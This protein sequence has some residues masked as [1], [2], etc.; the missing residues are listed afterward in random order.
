[1]AVRRAGIVRTS[2]CRSAPAMAL[3]WLP[4]MMAMKAI[5]KRLPITVPPNWRNFL[6][7][8][9]SPDYKALSGEAAY[10]RLY[11][12]ATKLGRPVAQ[13]FHLLQHV[14]W[15][16]ATPEQHR[17]NLE[18]FVV[19]ADTMLADP[20][21]DVNRRNRARYYVA[22]ALRELGQFDAAKARLQAMHAEWELAVA[23]QIMDTP[24]DPNF[25]NVYLDEQRTDASNGNGYGFGFGANITQLL[26]AVEARDID[27]FP[28]SL[29]GDKWANAVCRDLDDSFPPA[30]ASTKANCAKR[31]AAKTDKYANLQKDHDASQALLANPAKLNPLCTATPEDKREPILSEACRLSEY[32]ANQKRMEAGSASL[33]K[34]PKALD[35]QCK[36]LKFTLNDQPKTALGMACQKRREVTNEA[37]A[38]SLA[39]KFRTQPAEYDRMCTMKYPESYSDDP[40]ESACAR[41]KVERDD[42]RDTEIE[43]R[44]SKMSEAEIWAECEKTNGGNDA[45]GYK[46]RFRCSD[47]SGAREEA[48]WQTLESDPTLLAEKCALPFEERE[49]W[50]QMRCHYR[51][52]SM[53]DDAAKVMAKDHTAL[54]TAC[55]ATPVQDRDAILTKVCRG[56]RK[57]LVVRFDELPF[58]AASN[59]DWTEARDH[60]ELST[61]CYA[62]VEKADAAYARYA[63]DPKSLRA[64]CV[65]ETEFAEAPQ[66]ADTCARYAMGVDVFA[67]WRAADAADDDDFEDACLKQ[68]QSKSKS[69]AA[70]G[71]AAA[72]CVAKAAAKIIA[73]APV[74][75]K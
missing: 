41:V 61:A 36:S 55:A 32:Y 62:T 28:V 43:A 31:M 44:L 22:N 39:A 35:L 3:P 53:E 15:V 6:R 25:E 38:T 12:L 60:S 72:G 54:V 48:Q 68:A 27:Y 8:I 16:G 58:S 71:A 7:L 17:A 14:S 56:Y 26:E 70:A 9:A 51:Q 69:A 42:A 75:K 2:W 5:Q 4:D 13:R 49:E 33:L 65:P 59:G 1:M 46:L 34:S 50:Y 23:K 40:L 67:E 24:A 10:W 63:Q 74:R 30:T 20:D 57:C 19:D 37:E 18:R 45:E 64:S 29:M 21:F 73:P 52:E 47:I 66:D 11:W